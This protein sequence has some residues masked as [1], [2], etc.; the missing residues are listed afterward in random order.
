MPDYKLRPVAVEDARAISEIFNQPKVIDGTLRLPFTPEMGLA[1][2]IRACG[3]DT[4]MVVASVDGKAV[5]FIHLSRMN[6]RMAHCGKVFLAVHDAF[7]RIGIGRALMDAGLDIADNWM[8]LVRVELETMVDNAGAIALYQALGF[9]IEGRG[10]AGTLINGVYVDHYFM[11]R[12][13]P[14]PTRRAEDLRDAP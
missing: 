6:G 8:G 3:T 12:I 5:G 9:Q 2:W 14:A 13:R 4:R 1:D 7:H 11:A 10:R